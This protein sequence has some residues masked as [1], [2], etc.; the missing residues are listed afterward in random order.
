MPVQTVQTPAA[1]K[2]GARFRRRIVV[3][4][5][6]IGDPG[7]G[8]LE[9]RAALEDDFHH[10][11]VRLCARHGTLESIESQ[12]LRQPYHACQ[13]AGAA[14]QALVGQ[15]L[16]TV[17]HGVTRATEPT[18][19]CTHQLE[20]TGFA[21]ASAMRGESGMRYDIEVARRHV[22]SDGVACT[23]A[24]LWRD[25][26]T[27]APAWLDWR[28]AGSRIIS[29]GPH[30][31]IDLRHGMARWALENLSPELAEATL[32]LRRATVISAGREHDLDLRTH[33]VP[34]GHCYVQQP[35]RAERA[36][37]AVGSTWD[38]TLNPGALCAE[39]ADWLDFRREQPRIRP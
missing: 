8:R 30:H 16:Q 38:F 13:E 32:A 39:E 2:P 5:R 22:D 17:A 21:M 11:A 28:V 14:L 3:A 33:A 29:P 4:T 25:A 36:L 34:T 31:G 10:F 35:G 18:L 6:V 24:R 12:A 23:Q 20:L 1:S 9:M 19:Q 7:G 15:R 37:R 27:D 26:E